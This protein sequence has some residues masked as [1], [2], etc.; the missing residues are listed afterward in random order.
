[1][2]VTEVIWPCQS[3][4]KEFR[5]YRE[6]NY[7]V[8][9]NYCPHCG[10]INPVSFRIVNLNSFSD[11]LMA[12]G[13]PT[14]VA[15]PMVR[16]GVLR[17]PNQNSDERVTALLDDILPKKINTPLFEIIQQKY[18][19]YI[20]QYGKGKDDPNVVE[21]IEIPDVLA[22]KFYDLLVEAAEQIDPYD[23]A[24]RPTTTF[25]GMTVRF[26]TGLKTIRIVAVD[27]KTKAVVR[28]PI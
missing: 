13:L 20:M 4:G 1:M 3:C 11:M 2:I 10:K 7:T 25:L 21:Y 8:P 17:P 28:G 16:Q 27:K 6:N 18:T 19:L 24:I 26:C 23:K 5:I 9:N 15:E 12:T 22:D 14:G